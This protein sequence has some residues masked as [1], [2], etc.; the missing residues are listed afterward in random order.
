VIKRGAVFRRLKRTHCH[1]WEKS[2]TDGRYPGNAGQDQIN[3]HELPRPVDTVNE[4]H[5]HTDKNQRPNKQIT[6]DRNVV[7]M[8]D[9]GGETCKIR[10]GHFSQN[11]RQE[12]R[13]VPDDQMHPFFTGTK[14]QFFHVCRTG[15]QKI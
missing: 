13:S 5:A 15:F 8:T 3:C 1:G 12:K 10:I 6:C 9:L 2:H 7:K 14:V 11:H 4:Q